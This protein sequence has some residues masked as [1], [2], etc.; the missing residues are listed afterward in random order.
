MVVSFPAAIFNGIFCEAQTCCAVCWYNSSLNI[1]FLKSI[2]EKKIGDDH[3]C[4][5][6]CIVEN[7]FRESWKRT[8]RISS[9]LSRGHRCF[10]TRK[11][12]F[13]VFRSNFMRKMMHTDCVFTKVRVKSQQKLKHKSLSLRTILET[14]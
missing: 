14:R 3:S 4:R 6:R 5:G 1:L 12:G 9:N 7:L 2:V 8:I 13:F 10:E 11:D